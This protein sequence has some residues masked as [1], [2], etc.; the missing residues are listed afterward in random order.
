MTWKYDAPQGGESLKTRWRAVPFTRGTGL[1][2][3]CGMEKFMQTEFVIGIDNNIDAQ[4]FNRPA[5]AELYMD[6][7][8]LSRFAA[9][10]FDFAFS[11]H[12]LEHLPYKDV[13]GIL[14]EWMRVVRIGGHLVLY[15][16]DEDQYPKCA[17]PERGIAEE[18]YV[19]KDHKWNVN[20]DRVVAAM[21]RTGHNW[22]LVHFEKCSGDDEYS[23][24]FAF[25]KLK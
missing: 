13:P 16:P 21:E 8:E 14:R 15:L 20:Y 5:R 23:L 12:L 18:P 17:E 6:C 24:F 4:L 3:G 1:D 19:N 2:L 10:G 7:K 11:S 22:D 25:K 9:G